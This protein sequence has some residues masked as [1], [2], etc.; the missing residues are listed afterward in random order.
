MAEESDFFS[1]AGDWFGDVMDGVQDATVDA[2]GYRIR[3]SSGAYD[4][5]KEPAPAEPVQ[6]TSMN[7]NA[8]GYSNTEIAMV[9]GGVVLLAGGVL[10]FISSQG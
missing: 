9:V 7:G 8:R 10:W 1:S 2:L 5:L 3:E 6:P 4:G